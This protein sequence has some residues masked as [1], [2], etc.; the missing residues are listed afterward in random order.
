MY[1]CWNR[2]PYRTL[3]A[4]ESETHTGWLLPRGGGQART[5]GRGTMTQ[6]ARE[7]APQVLCA[8]GPRGQPKTYMFAECLEGVRVGNRTQI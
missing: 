1:G 4:R 5:G 7:P 8:A 2:N 6:P 3:A